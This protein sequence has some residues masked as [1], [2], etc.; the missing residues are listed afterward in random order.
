MKNFY[1]HCISLLLCLNVLLIL[2]QPGQLHASADG[3]TMDGDYEEN[4]NISASNGAVNNIVSRLTE[5]QYKMVVWGAD[6]DAE[7]KNTAGD[8]PN[9]P[10]ALSSGEIRIKMQ[11]GWRL[12]RED[13]VTRLID[14]TAHDRTPEGL[15]YLD[16]EFPGLVIE[17][18]W[19][20][21]TER[22][23]K[24]RQRGERLSG[25]TLPDL[26]QWYRIIP[27]V[28]FNT[29]PIITS[30]E[31]NKPIL[32]REEQTQASRVLEILKTLEGVDMAY[33]A[34]PLIESTMPS[35][36]HQQYELAGEFE[37]TWSGSS[38]WRQH[39]FH[40][41]PDIYDTGGDYDHTLFPED[42]LDPVCEA[43]KCYTGG[44]NVWPAWDDGIK[45]SGVS[46]GYVEAEWCLGNGNMKW[47]LC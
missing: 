9:V 15:L 14:D 26:S 37:Y 28:A 35:I 32:S 43:S 36:Y 29:R 44:L 46:I 21:D 5:A 39:Q 7:S 11:K 31:I 38:D 16:Y 33:P 47:T 22:L 2:V 3:M 27:S 30:A 45:G 6:H 20:S 18:L 23:R 19:G 1:V 24:L 12:L 42:L 8:V 13:C 25:R 34:S 17:P 10:I 4:E 41:G 40:T